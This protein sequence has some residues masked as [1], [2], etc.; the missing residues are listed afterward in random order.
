MTKFLEGMNFDEDGIPPSGSQASKLT[1]MVRKKLPEWI[2]TE[3]APM[4]EKSM[5]DKGVEVTL[6]Q[7]TQETLNVDFR[8][9]FDGHAYVRSSVLLEFGARSTGRPAEEHAIACDAAAAVPGVVF[10]TTTVQAMAVERTFWEKATAAHVYTLQQNLKKDRFSRHWHDLHYIYKSKHW[11]LALKDVELAKKVAT[12]KS[13]FFKEKD[14][15]SQVIDYAKAVSGQMC[16]VPSGDALKA[17]EADYKTMQE[18]G[19]TAADA[20]DFGVI[21]DSC[22]EMEVAINSNFKA[23]DS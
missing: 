8:S 18:S 10:P 13:F 21:I 14:K 2:A 15:N 19:I 12:H 22:R 3:F 20:P 23:M 4:L 9:H 5:K 6:R 11:P 17:L 16:M 1:E 7:S